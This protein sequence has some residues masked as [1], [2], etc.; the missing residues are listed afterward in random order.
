ME[1]IKKNLSKP[2]YWLLLGVIICLTVLVFYNRTVEHAT[3]TNDDDEPTTP[4]T[5]ELPSIPRVNVQVNELPVSQEA[6]RHAIGEVYRAD[7]SAIKNL[8]DIATALQQGNGIQIPGKL[9]VKGE[10]DLVGSVKKLK[11]D[12]ETNLVGN[13]NANG[14][15]TVDGETN[16]KNKLIVSEDT[17]LNS[18]LKV[19]GETTLSN[20]TGSQYVATDANKNLV[21]VVP[22]AALISYSHTTGTTFSPVEGCVANYG[23][24]HC[25]KDIL[26][27][28]VDSP[29]N[30]GIRRDNNKLINSSG[31]TVTCLVR[32]DSIGTLMPRSAGE[33][34]IFKNSNDLNVGCYTTNYFG[35]KA[36]IPLRASTIVKLEPDSTISF[37]FRS[38]S[39]KDY[40]SIGVNNTIVT[41]I[42]LY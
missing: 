9:V 13:V 4:S 35:E 22:A 23:P 33:I 36:P 7:I 32:I 12:G 17:S 29:D 14:K 6:L 42:G 28:G 24:D 18:K 10:T 34:K 15:L 11:V 38:Y 20:L 39:T 27:N 37:S 5:S 26:L 19:T 2:T 1:Y 41:I 30:K 21:S 3:N 25:T 31:K 40:G 8:S 16:L